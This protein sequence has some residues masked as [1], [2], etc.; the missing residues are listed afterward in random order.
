MKKITVLLV[1]DNKQWLGSLKEELR[2]YP[3]LDVI[4][5]V[6]DAKTAVEMVKDFEIDVVVTDVVMQETDGFMLLESIGRIKSKRLVVIMMSAFCNDVMISKSASMGA[7]YFLRKPF[8]PGVLYDKINFFCSGSGVGTSKRILSDFAETEDL[9]IIVS[10]MI[11]TIGVPAHIKGY[12]FLRDC[13]IWTVKDMEIINA[14]TKELY[15]GIAKKYKTTPSRV[16]RAIRHAIEISWQRGD[17][18]VLNS[19]FG[20]TVKFNKDKPTNSEFIA[21]IAD[22][23]RLHMK[24]FNKSAM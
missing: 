17:I 24:Q 11:K 7:T 3:T 16:E 19:V 13:I 21:M 12:Q 4:A 5:A 10:D 18:D 20:H 14:V 1:D 8:S 15:P 6:E 9:E 23:I 2:T 22:R